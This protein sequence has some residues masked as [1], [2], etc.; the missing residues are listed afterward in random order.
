MVTR[1]LGAQVDPLASRSLPGCL[2]VGFAAELSSKVV[3]LS[4]PLSSITVT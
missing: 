2:L 4:N 3:V 1:V